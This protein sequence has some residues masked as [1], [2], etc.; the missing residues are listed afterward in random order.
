MESILYDSVILDELRNIVV[1]VN[2]NKKQ[3]ISD[4]SQMPMIPSD[5]HILEEYFGD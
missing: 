2:L 4:I 1:Q 5:K 3:N